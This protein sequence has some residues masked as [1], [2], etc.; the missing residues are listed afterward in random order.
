MLIG[1]GEGR[2]QKSHGRH[3]AEFSYKKQVSDV[4]LAI[5]PLGLL[6]H[7]PHRQSLRKRGKPFELPKHKPAFLNLRGGADEIF[8]VELSGRKHGM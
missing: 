3:Q 7:V 8:I 1:T 6:E 4:L 2:A 5:Y